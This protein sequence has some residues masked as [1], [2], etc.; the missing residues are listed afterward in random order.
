MVAY[1]LDNDVG[2]ELAALLGAYGEDVTTAAREG[3]RSASDDEHLLRAAGQE[4]LPVTHNRRDFL[5]LHQAWLRWS[6]AWGVQRS[7]AGILVIP[8]PPE[9]T[10]VRA[11][12]DLTRFC[13]SG[14]YLGNGL[15][16]RKF[17]GRRAT[18]EQ[19]RIGLG[20]TSR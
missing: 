3:L 5:L 1:Y 13:Q 12:R 6:T 11:A 14:R 4:R 7:H 19:W 2:Q 8:Q 16:L 10:V 9:L 18:W 20:R 15:F 17:G